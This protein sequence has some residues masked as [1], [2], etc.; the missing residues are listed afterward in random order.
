[1]KIENK[2]IFICKSDIDNH[3]YFLSKRG[4]GNFNKA[5]L[6]REFEDYIYMYDADKVDITGSKVDVRRQRHTQFI[7]LNNFY[8]FIVKGSK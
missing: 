7:E 6:K 8:R 1:M 5:Y 2:T 4:F 3:Y